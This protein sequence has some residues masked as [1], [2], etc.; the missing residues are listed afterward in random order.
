MA[1]HFTDKEWNDIKSKSSGDYTSNEEEL[2]DKERLEH[3]LDDA[4]IRKEQKKH[5]REERKSKREDAKFA[6]ENP[7]S[8]FAKQYEKVHAQETKDRVAKKQSQ[9]RTKRAARKVE[10]EVNEPVRVPQYKAPD[11][12][13]AKSGYT[14]LNYKPV[15]GSTNYKP[16]SSAPYF[17][18][19]GGSPMGSGSYFKPMKVPMVKSSKPKRTGRTKKQG[20]TG[21]SFF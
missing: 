7:A 3:E 18:P 21:F 9:A 14:P 5:E 15:S 19:M 13:V 4:E 6:K 20:N 12:N 2:K 8:D 1:I 17:K 11:M 16:V 10:K